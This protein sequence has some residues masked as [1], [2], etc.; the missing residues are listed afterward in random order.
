L[1][2]S[3]SEVTIPSEL[4]AKAQQLVDQGHFESIEQLTEIAVQD[5]L[6]KHW[7]PNF[8]LQS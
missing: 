3:E 6:R 4:Q 2:M 5:Y 1:E 8:T 7:D